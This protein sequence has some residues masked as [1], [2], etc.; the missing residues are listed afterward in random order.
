MEEKTVYFHLRMMASHT[1]NAHGLN[2]F[3]IIMMLGA[4]LKWTR[5]LMKLLS[6]TIVD[7]IV[8]WLQVSYCSSPNTIL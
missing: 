8:M 6:L 4:P 2:P 1:R 3:G 7:L 5:L